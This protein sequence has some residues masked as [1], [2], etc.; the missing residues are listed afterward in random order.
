MLRERGKLII[1][2]NYVIEMLIAWGAF[3]LAYQ[4]YAPRHHG[5][6]PPYA[7]YR[8]LLLLSLLSWSVV[9]WFTPSYFSA[10][11]RSIRWALWKTLQAGLLSG[12]LLFAG[13][14]AFKLQYTSRGLEVLAIAIAT[15]GIAAERVGSR[16]LMRW[17]RTRG[18][19]YRQ[20]VIVGT[21]GA[22][23]RVARIIEGHAEW[24]L[25]ILGFFA[26][27]DGV[28]RR[29]VGGRVVLGGVRDLPE[30][31]RTNVV[32]EV[33]FCVPRQRR[34]TLTDLFLKCDELGVKTRVMLNFLP[35]SV[36]RVTLEQLDG[37][38]MLTYSRTPTSELELA[39]KRAIDLVGSAVLLALLS[40]VLAL[41]AI[42]IWLESGGPILFRQKRVGLYGRVF[43]LYKFRSM[44]HDAEARQLTLAAM[45]EMDG[46]VFKIRRD[47]R[48]TAVG[49]VI[50]RL[51]LDELPQ[52][53][54]VLRGEM[55]LVGPRPLPVSEAERIQPWQRR[56]LSMKPGLTCL[57][58]VSGRNTVNFQRWMRLD[59]EYIDNW[60]LWLD[61]K[62]LLRTVPA[63]LES[64][65]AW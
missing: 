46:P 51:S 43:T 23:R 57:W 18:H 58:Q 49:R 60:S 59:L 22:A 31:M 56:R 40:P 61:T 5:A 30:F 27:E 41:V 52:L 53:L 55:S 36:A 34:D 14:A 9:L 11:V 38:P 48:V 7:Q 13:T 29:T 39:A 50:R 3:W 44:V 26:D 65:G 6:F 10:R 4:V 54:N 8:S 2:A 45:N 33:I 1:G 63:V 17:V 15:A 32:D 16:L 25:R 64:R 21:G 47:P 37:I 28:R 19:N 12:L 42:A 35:R 20:V 62:I 24:G